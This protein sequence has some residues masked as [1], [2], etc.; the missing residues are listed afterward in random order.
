[1]RIT[2]YLFIVLVWYGPISQRAYFIRGHSYI[3]RYSYEGRGIAILLN[4]NRKGL[5][6]IKIHSKTGPKVDS[7]IKY[8]NILLLYW[9]WNCIVLYWNCIVLYWNCILIVL[10]MYQ[11]CSFRCAY[12]IEF[13]CCVIYS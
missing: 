8:L 9:Y 3:T 10:E 12:C 6:Y 11:N 7:F 2:F 13:G 4:S 5:R 1:M